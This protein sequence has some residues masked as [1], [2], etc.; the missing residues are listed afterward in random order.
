M[1]RLVVILALSG[2]LLALPDS[3]NAA[4]EWGCEPG[5]CWWGYNYLTPDPDT[6]CMRYSPWNYWYAMWIDK[7]NG[8]TTYHELREWGVAWEC[9]F[10]PSGAVRWWI[11]A[12]DA[13]C[14]GYL[15]AWGHYFSGGSSYL[16]VELYV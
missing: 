1:K 15:Q 13:G 9:S 6:C 11:V 12:S 14:N 5:I 10:Y 8:G 7:L 4:R 16:R 2:A 3:A